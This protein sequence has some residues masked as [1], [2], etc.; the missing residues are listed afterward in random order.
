MGKSRKWLSPVHNTTPFWGRGDPLRDHIE[1]KARLMALPL[2]VLNFRNWFPSSHVAF[3]VGWSWAHFQPALSMHQLHN[4]N[5]PWGRKMQHLLWCQDEEVGMS[6]VKLSDNSYISARKLYPKRENTLF[7]WLHVMSNA[8]LVFVLC[9]KAIKVFSL[10]FTQPYPSLLQSH[11]S[12]GTWMC[13]D[14]I[15]KW[16]LRVLYWNLWSPACGTIVR[17]F[18]KLRRWGLA[19]R[20]RLWVDGSLGLNYP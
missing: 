1:H 15:L 16:R 13:C 9:L 19:G 12:V 20:M 17:G 5:Q 8:C 18:G 3:Y 7:Q 4:S 6:A 2:R 10:L 14:R 11:L